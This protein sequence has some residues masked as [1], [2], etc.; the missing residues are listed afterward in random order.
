MG[1]ILRVER[2]KSGVDE[3]IRVG[4]QACIMV[5]GN[6][7]GEMEK[8]GRRLRQGYIDRGE[9]EMGV[10]IRRVRTMSR[11]ARRV[12]AMAVAATATPREINGLGLS[13][14]SSP[15]MLAADPT[16]PGSGMLRRAEMALLNQFS[17]V[18]RRKL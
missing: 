17:V 13:N 8:E 3:E 7:E 16:R 2:R 11:G 15:P 9:E 12:A 1:S 5:A 14:M 6:R 10:T 4:M 18:L